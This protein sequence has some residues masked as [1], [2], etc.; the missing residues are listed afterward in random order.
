MFYLKIKNEN[1]KN[2]ILKGM[3]LFLKYSNLILIHFELA[4]SSKTSKEEYNVPE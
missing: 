1:L 2:L 4:R 3:A